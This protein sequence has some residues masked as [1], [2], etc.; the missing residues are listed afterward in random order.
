MKISDLLEHINVNTAGP[1]RLF[2]AVL[3]LLEKADKPKFLVITSAVATISGME[4]VPW[5]VSSYGA[6]KAAANWLVRRIHFEN[7]GFIAIAAHP[8]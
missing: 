6:S 8:G 3:P 4:Y 2:Q 7:E 1:V 5:N